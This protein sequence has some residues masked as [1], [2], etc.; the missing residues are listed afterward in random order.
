MDAIGTGGGEELEE[1]EEE[2]NIMC[3]CE[4]KSI[5]NIK[6]KICH[7]DPLASPKC[8]CIYLYYIL[9]ILHDTVT[10]VNSVRFH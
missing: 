5:F 8:W 7:C 3:L 10:S 1:V 6:R 2:G 4:K 9:L